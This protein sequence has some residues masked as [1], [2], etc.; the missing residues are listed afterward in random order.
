MENKK[1]Q[2]IYLFRDVF[3]TSLAM[4]ISPINLICLI[5]WAIKKN[6][7]LLK[8]GLAI[9]ATIII[10]MTAFILAL[11]TVYKVTPTELFKNGRFYIAEDLGTV[12]QSGYLEVGGRML[13]ISS[14]ENL[15]L[16]Y[17]AKKVVLYTPNDETRL[18]LYEDSGIEVGTLSDEELSTKMTLED[19]ADFFD[20]YDEKLFTLAEKLGINEKNSYVSYTQGL[21]KNVKSETR[22]ASSGCY[23]EVYVL[24]DIGAKTY[25][26]IRIA[27]YTGESPS[28][29]ITKYALTLVNV[30]A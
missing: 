3:F 22:E 27:D 8:I 6:K 14:E 15:T 13:Q 5:Y 1:E 9:T 29:L 12:N 10:T 17:D 7:R 20:K 2:S 16:S 23:T 11:C 4:I 18:V 26:S 28:T 19:P 24:Q 30:L 21:F 25:L